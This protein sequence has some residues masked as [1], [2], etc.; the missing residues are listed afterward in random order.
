MRGAAPD[1]DPPDRPAAARARLAGAPVDVQALLHLAV[2]LG[3]RVVVDRAPRR[4]M[5]S[6]RTPRIASTGGPRRPGGASRRDAQRVQPRAPERLVGVDVADAG[7]E[8]LVHEQR[9]EAA[10]RRPAGGAGS[11]AA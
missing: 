7:E 8:G 6:A 2:A 4:S 9:L 10:L 5:A 1:D 11:P 3:R